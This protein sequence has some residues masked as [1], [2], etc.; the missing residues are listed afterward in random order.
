MTTK[1][2]IGQKVW[3]MHDDKPQCMP[4]CSIYIKATPNKSIVRGTIEGWREP[5]IRYAFW[6]GGAETT[7]TEYEED[8][9]ATKEELCDAV[10]NK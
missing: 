4:V 2:S 5:N 10:F 9:F 1:F 6:R 8:V 7:Y 3:F